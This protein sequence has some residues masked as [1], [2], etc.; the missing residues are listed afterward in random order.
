MNVLTG[1]L[2]ITGVVIVAAVCS[3]PRPPSSSASASTEAKDDSDRGA[4]YVCRYAIRQRLHSSA[5]PE[6]AEQT[7]SSVEAR[8]DRT[9]RVVVRYTTTQQPRPQIGVCLL[10]PAGADWR[11]LSI[12]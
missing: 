5:S 10:Q 4:Y 2:I 9:R 8:A 6:F 7:P 3:P 11:V 1:V 12:E